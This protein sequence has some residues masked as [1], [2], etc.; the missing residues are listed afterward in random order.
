MSSCHCADDVTQHKGATDVVNGS[1]SIDTTSGIVYMGSN[2]KYMYVATPAPLLG[3]GFKQP[4]VAGW[5]VCVCGGG[6]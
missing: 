2:D 4:G 1:P 6:R 5:C 3:D